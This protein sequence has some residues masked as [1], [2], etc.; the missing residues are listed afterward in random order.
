MKAFIILGFL[1]GSLTAQNIKMDISKEYWSQSKMVKAS[2]AWINREIVQTDTDIT[3]IGI[4][5][6]QE[7]QYKVVEDKKE[8]YHNGCFFYL[9]DDFLSRLSQERYQYK[10]IEDNAWVTSFAWIVY[11]R[12]QKKY[13]L[14][15]D[16]NRFSS[17]SRLPYP[18]RVSLEKYNT[19][20]KI[21]DWINSINLDVSKDYMK[22]VGI[23]NKDTFIDGLA[24]N[25]AK[26]VFNEKNKPQILSIQR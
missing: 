19:A 13:N 25:I 2:K 6:G 20:E 8:F 12:K 22:K 17:F 4:F 23:S 18:A 1:F 15:I 9:D 5:K 10:A 21:I 7:I 14:E 11:D 24:S 3:A 16:L 26:N